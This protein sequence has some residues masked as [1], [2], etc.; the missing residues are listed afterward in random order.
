MRKVL[1]FIFL[2]N[3]LAAAAD[4]FL[5]GIDSL[6]FDGKYSEAIVLLEEKYKKTV[7]D[8]DLAWMIAQQCALISEV[9]A[10]RKARLDLYEKGISYCLPY[11]NRQNADAKQQ[12]NLIYWYTINYASK[13][14]EQ[15]IFAG[16]EGMNIIPDVFKLID[17]C[18]EL[19][20]EFA[21]AFFFRGKFYGE[22]PGFLG[23]NRMKM[24]TDYAKSLKYAGDD[25]RMYIEL[26]ISKSLF[27]RNWQI[28]N[29]VKES[30]KANIDVNDLISADKN[31]KDLGISLLNDVLKTLSEKKDLSFREK[32]ILTETQ[33]I[34]KEKDKD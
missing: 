2:M 5:D 4:P 29:K 10:E 3:L 27:K 20:P 33:N 23:G 28:D 12:S 11:M 18:I 1:A 25:D 15:G 19:N 30:S 31:D 32:N 22:I 17:K 13:I 24:E 9:T 6:N 16:K 34:L 21:N 8:P 26:E 14:K 7:S